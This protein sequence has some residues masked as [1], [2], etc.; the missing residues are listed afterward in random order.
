MELKNCKQK[1]S[2]ERQC[3]Q[4]GN[5]KCT[6]NASAKRNAKHIELENEKNVTAKTQMHKRLF[7]HPLDSH[8]RA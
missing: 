2:A 5:H 1:A 7:G 6:K 3:K 8:L 4:N